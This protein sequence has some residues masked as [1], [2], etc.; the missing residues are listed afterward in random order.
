MDILESSS[1]E[2]WRLT[3]VKPIGLPAPSPVC[4]ASAAS[5]LPTPCALELNHFLSPE[6]SL[7]TGQCLLS[8]TE[9][10]VKSPKGDSYRRLKGTKLCKRTQER[11]GK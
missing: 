4:H 3:Q 11:G 9:R 5:V 6:S 10:R 7:W 1:S 2:M 8:I